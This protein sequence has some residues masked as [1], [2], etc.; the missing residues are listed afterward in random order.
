MLTVLFGAD[1]SRRAHCALGEC[2]GDLPPRVW[3]ADKYSDAQTPP[4]SRVFTLTPN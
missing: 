4:H 2:K 3:G 1:G